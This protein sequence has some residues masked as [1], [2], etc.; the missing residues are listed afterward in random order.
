MKKLLLLLLL[1]LG[2]IGSANSES[3]IQ[4]P[5]KQAVRDYLHS[6][7]PS[8][9]SLELELAVIQ[10]EA[11]IEMLAEQYLI[12]IDEEEK[13]NIDMLIIEQREH[14]ELLNGL[15]SR[16]YTGYVSLFPRDYGLFKNHL[17]FSVT[18]SSIGLEWSVL[19]S[20]DTGGYFY[21]D[22]KSINYLHGDSRVSSLERLLNNEKLQFDTVD[23]QALAWFVSDVLFM[24]GNSGALLIRDMSD[25]FEGGYVIRRNENSINEDCQSTSSN[26]TKDEFNS[27][28]LEEKLLQFMGINEKEIW[29]DECF[30]FTDQ[31]LTTL[32]HDQL[33]EIAK[34]RG[35]DSLLGIVL[36]SLKKEGDNWILEFTTTYGWMHENQ[37]L[38]LHN[39]TFS[40][41]YKVSLTESVLSRGLYMGIPELVY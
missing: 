4:L 20:M 18:I 9:R 8:P 26:Y 6:N 16:G 23:P 25:I 11:I 5:S 36:P 28:S 40:P 29:S 12:T 15:L 7:L 31:E 13:T 39:I 34:K 24:H 2:L 33:I 35:F 41:E 37:L 19:P 10:T 3:N 22:G 1:S 32:S 27:L 21:T 17:I 14:I 38:R 30:G